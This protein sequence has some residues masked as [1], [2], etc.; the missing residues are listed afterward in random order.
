MSNHNFF[1]TGIA[2]L[3]T[4]LHGIFPGD[5][6]VFQIDSIDQFIP[7][8]HAFCKENNFQN[9][10]L[11]Y[12]R[13]ANHISLLPENIK[14]DIFEVHPEK[15]F[16]HFID[17]I[18]TVIEKYG[19]W[20][21]YVFDSLSDLA[22]DWYSDEMVANFFMLTC[23]YL[24]DF[25]TETY[26]AL[27]RNRH[28]EDT[29]SRIHKTAQIII[30]VYKKN[31]NYYI[32]PIKVWKRHSRT[33]YM[34]HVWKDEKFVPIL[35][36]SKTSEILT[37]YNLQWGDFTTKPQDIWA[38]TFNKAYHIYNKSYNSSI[39]NE[40]I[41]LLK[42]K[43]IRM[44]I[45]QD[46]KLSFLAKEFFNIEDLINI[47]KRMIGTGLIG[48]KSLGMLLAQSILKKNDPNWNNKLE[49]HDSFFIGSDVFYT[50]LV[51]NNCWWIRYKIRKKKDFSDYAVKARNILE[52]GDF[53]EDIIK[54]FRKILNYYG[55][56]PIIVRSSSLLED[57]YGN[58]FS[59]KY[60]SIFL[61]NQGTPDE[62][63]YEF[64]NAVRKVYKSTLSEEALFYRLNRNLLDKDE[65]MALLVQRVSGSLYGNLFFPQLAGVG[66]S[67]NPFVWNKEIIPEDG[68]IRLVFG[69]G[70]R[71]VE[72]FDDDYTRIVALGASNRRPETSVLE[73]QK[74]NQR[75][76]DVIDLEN[77]EF[78][79]KYFDDI[80]LNSPKLPIELF[81]TRDFS[82]E[83]KFKE[84]GKIRSYYYLDLDKIILKT[85]LIKD[86][87]NILQT[88]SKIY[89]YPIDIEFAINFTK[90]SDY[91]IYILQCRPFQIKNE[92]EII[93]EPQNIKYED[94][95]FKT[96]GPII[97]KGMSTK[98]D[99][100]IY[101]VPELYGKLPNQQRSLIARLIGR[102]NQKLVKTEDK[103]ILLAG[104]G[105]WATSSPSLGIPVTFYEIN[106]ISIIC[107]IAE[108]HENLTP[109][110][111]LG[112]HFFNDL[113]ENNM[114]YLSINPKNQ[115]SILNK[116]KLNNMDNCL[117][118]ILPEAVKYKDIIK[119]I[120]YNEESNQK[121]MKIYSDT[122]NQ[123]AIL[124]SDY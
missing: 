94:I 83:Q 48:G 99:I 43:I 69:L 31:E 75:K 55:Q 98:V 18:F 33:M 92:N 82:I 3:D 46:P 73:T 27:I 62:R 104:P 77:N 107:E 87:Y 9:R 118:K 89:K 16:E 25:D 64:I 44:A 38:K 101:V 59:G 119:I 97:G 26:F 20:S 56:S 34:L 49:Q 42:E 106:K 91:K 71:A 24:F 61:P 115:G 54:Q 88:L 19:K 68:L 85:P 70:T 60:E 47:G 81:G 116:E 120:E 110:A 117:D 74:Y 78:L 76:V 67:Y 4:I 114:L 29:I 63:L 57:A 50:Y 96:N 37:E 53:P 30:D 79:T 39:K 58:A 1:S 86:I 95:I 100:L 102:I 22:V 45:T 105:R 41:I 123:T 121:K 32:H 21:A 13:F 103:I 40:D 112:T 108:M 12:F 113:V 111:S 11:V 72:R 66:Y 7:F 15:G 84:L 35:K 8:V 93:E 17:D 51:I 52:K 14:A 90:K 124:Y 6:I 65:Q 36:S 5:N 80:V 23:P 2:G 28:S 109:D 122:I 10:K